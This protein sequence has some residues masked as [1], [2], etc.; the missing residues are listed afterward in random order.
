[1]QGKQSF[2]IQTYCISPDWRK[3]EFWAQFDEDKKLFWF[4]QAEW[5]GREEEDGPDQITLWEDNIRTRYYPKN[6]IQ[7][8]TTIGKTEGE[9]E[10]FD[11]GLVVQE[12]FEQVANNQATF[13]IQEPAVDE[14][15]I[16]ITV[17]YTNGLDR[18]ILLVDPNT[19]FVV[20]SDRYQLTDEQQWAYVD[21]IELLEYN[22]PFDP[23]AFTIDISDDTI[24]LDQVSQ[25][26][27]MAQGDMNDVEIAS[28]IVRKAL[29][30]W[31]AGDYSQAGNLFGGAPP[32]LLTERYGHL[33]PINI[34]HIGEPILISYRK[35]WFEVPCKYDVVRY[36]PE[37]PR[38]SQIETIEAALHA[39]A[40]DGQPGRWYVS[41]DRNP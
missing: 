10:E 39:L 18:R 1:M 2:H 34:I 7:L 41:I 40:V 21:G 11:P 5:E 31:A 3:D 17:T 35:S 28:R 30:V 32:K 37:Y 26:V 15:L 6:R 14:M 19:D 36:G 23:N 24:T 29:E 13:E 12:V 33:R 9:L 25:Q 4:R 16:T 8:I 22:Q 38:H 20:R 27:G